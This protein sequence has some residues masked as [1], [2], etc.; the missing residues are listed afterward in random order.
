MLQPEISFN[1]N[2]RF[3]LDAMYVVRMTVVSFNYY[4]YKFS[5]F[6]R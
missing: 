6:N 3:R 1:Q 4:F 5:F 2:V